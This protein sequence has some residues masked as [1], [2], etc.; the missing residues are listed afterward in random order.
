MDID[1]FSGDKDLANDR[2]FVLDKNV[3]HVRRTDPYGFWHCA[4][5]KGGLPEELQGNFTSFSEARQAVEGYL[6]KTKKELKEIITN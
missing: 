1:D 4:Y 5:E 3:L 2:K 6:Q